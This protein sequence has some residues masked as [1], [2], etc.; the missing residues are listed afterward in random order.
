MFRPE[1]FR[2]GDGS[3]RMLPGRRAGDLV[4][5]APVRP[6]VHPYRLLLAAST[7]LAACSGDEA[8]APPNPSVPAELRIV[9]GD[10]L[11]G[12]AG[13]VLTAE[14]V[15]RAV[16]EVGVGVSGVPITWQV[17]SGSGRFR[18]YDRLLSVGQGSTDSDGLARINFEPLA[19]GRSTVEARVATHPGRSVTFTTEATSTVI[20]I[21]L[22]MV[23]PDGSSAVTV[24]VGSRV[25]WYNWLSTAQVASTSE[26]PG[27]SRFRSA[28]LH[29]G[30]RFEFVP[31]A[32]GTW[33]F[34]DEVSG[35]RGTLTAR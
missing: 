4:G 2:T 24:P 11:Q 26:P 7:V 10:G 1:S 22:W 3:R 34:F 31:D 29:R 25:E 14:F 8:V 6:R 12:K 28:R 23:A 18:H 21:W 30:E 33:D 13:E 32:V 16:D 9:S 17:V 27:G 35:I 5:A 19:L 20:G 15:V